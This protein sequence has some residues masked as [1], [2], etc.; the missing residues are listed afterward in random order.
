MSNDQ[1]ECFSK[2]NMHIQGIMRQYYHTRTKNTFKTKL[3]ANPSSYK[4]RW[5]L[6][7]TTS[8]TML[9]WC[10]CNLWFYSTCRASL[11]TSF[12]PSSPSVAPCQMFTNHQA[13]QEFSHSLKKNSYDVRGNIFFLFLSSKN[14]I[15]YHV[16][17]LTKNVSLLTLSSRSKAFFMNYRCL[18]DKTRFSFSNLFK[19]FSKSPIY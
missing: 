15:I 11:P 6:N 5:W 16:Y 4:D 17:V 13:H 8:F 1:Y 3:Q 14:C 7:H 10:I 18:F 19:P 2:F 12:F 9:L